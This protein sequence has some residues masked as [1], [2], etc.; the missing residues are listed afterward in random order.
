MYLITEIKN[1]PLGARFRHGQTWYCKFNNWLDPHSGLHLGFDELHPQNKL[2]LNNPYLK[3]G[4]FTND[5]G[6]I[7][8]GEDDIPF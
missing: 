2:I 4:V 5:K 6:K 3:V 1:V 8:L 7:L